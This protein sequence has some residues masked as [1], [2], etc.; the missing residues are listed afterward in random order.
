MSWQ[1][2]TL[3]NGC[4]RAGAGCS[5]REQGAGQL[6]GATT[7]FLLACWVEWGLPLVYLVFVRS[8]PRK[9]AMAVGR[10]SAERVRR[11]V[12][13]TAAPCHAFR[14]AMCCAD[15]GMASPL[16]LAEIVG[17][18]RTVGETWC[19]KPRICPGHGYPWSFRH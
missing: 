8:L 18:R 14:L 7:G 10:S 5:K 3:T 1:I 11:A 9:K 16:T 4:A 2:S 17:G 13:G 12:E 19:L 15:S 6:S